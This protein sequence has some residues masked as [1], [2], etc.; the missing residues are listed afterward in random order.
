M[1][2]QSEKNLLNGNI[3]SRL[4]HNMM[5]FDPLTAEISRQVGGTLSFFNRF[6]VLA[7]L[8]HQRRST[9]VNPTH[10]AR[11]LAISG[12]VDYTYIFRGSCPL[13][14][15]CQVQNS[16]CPQSCVLLY[17][18]TGVLLQAPDQW[19][20]VKLCSMVQGMELRN[21]CSSSFSLLGAKITEFHNWISPAGKFTANRKVKQM[22]LTTSLSNHNCQDSY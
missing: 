4:P 3:F 21:F 22:R 7:L 20:S 18:I 15:F 14:E 2:R 9:E 8:L 13:T 5:N 10:F 11:R 17:W 1:Y 6:R 16:L 19:A 12:L